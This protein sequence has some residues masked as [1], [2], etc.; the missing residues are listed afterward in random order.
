[1]PPVG[2]HTDI[3]GVALDINLDTKVYCLW[4]IAKFICVFKPLRGHY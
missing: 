2:G 4:Q 1:M 3:S